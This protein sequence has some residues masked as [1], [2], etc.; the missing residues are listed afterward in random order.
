MISFAN[1]FGDNSS[2]S[3]FLPIAEPLSFTNQ[4]Q[5]LKEVKID[6][7]SCWVKVK[8]VLSADMKT[9][10]STDRKNVFWFNMNGISVIRKKS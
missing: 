3:F 7:N 2:F 6:V 1:H 5:V 4:E 10:Y 8:E 9:H